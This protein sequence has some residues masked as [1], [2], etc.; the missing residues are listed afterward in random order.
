MQRAAASA[1]IQHM[2]SAVGREARRF[3]AIG[4]FL[5]FGAVMAGLA[6]ITLLCRGT[7][8]DRLW[9]L[10]PI[11]HNRLVPLGR[12][13]GILFLLLGA[14][15]TTAGVGWFRRRCLESLPKKFKNDIANEPGC[16]SNFEIG[17]SEDIFDCP[18]YAPSR[19][20]NKT[21]R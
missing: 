10:N 20:W 12:T 18:H 9:V 2:K 5:F 13:V 19:D 1:Y 3:T 14:A 7:P 6:A 17:N 4:I 16:R 11:A 15:L 21:G 8:L